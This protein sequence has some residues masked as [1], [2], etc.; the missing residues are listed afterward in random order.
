MLCALDALDAAAAGAFVTMSCAHPV[1][2]HIASPAKS[3]PA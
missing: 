1:T 3:A 2:A